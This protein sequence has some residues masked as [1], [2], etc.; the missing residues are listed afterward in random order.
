MLPLQNMLHVQFRQLTSINLSNNRYFYKPTLA[1][2]NKKGSCADSPVLDISGVL[3]VYLQ[4]TV[5]M[6]SNEGITRKERVP[7]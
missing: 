5:T 6:K 7:V 1:F 4:K 2:K 3:K